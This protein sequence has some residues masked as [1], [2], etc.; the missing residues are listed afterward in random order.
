MI[1]VEENFDTARYQSETESSKPDIKTQ[2][3][4]PSVM[5]LGPGISK[6][7]IIQMIQTRSDRYKL[8]YLK[9]RKVDQILRTSIGGDRAVLILHNFD[10]DERRLKGFPAFNICSKWITPFQ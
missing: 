9:E 7:A 2:S 1:N 5:D 10:D 6:F 4:K 3:S 8:K